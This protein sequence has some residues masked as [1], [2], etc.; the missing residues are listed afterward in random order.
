MIF[1]GILPGL[2]EADEAEIPARGS[3][4]SEVAGHTAA[5]QIFVVIA[6]INDLPRA[7][8]SVV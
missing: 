6:A 3:A 1:I 8:A 2:A 7:L 5:V 4:D